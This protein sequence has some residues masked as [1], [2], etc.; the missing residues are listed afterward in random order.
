MGVLVGGIDLVGL[1]G[2]RKHEGVKTLFEETRSEV[3]VQG[4][5]GD[6]Q[7]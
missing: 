5:K 6:L 4:L 2:Q 3:K 1:Q 7:G